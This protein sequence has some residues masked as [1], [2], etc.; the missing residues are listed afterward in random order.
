MSTILNSMKE[1]YDNR[2]LLYSMVVRDFKGK[3]KNSFFGFL[4]HFITPAVMIVLFYIVFTNIR[5]SPIDD[6]WIYLCAGMFPF[7]FFQTNIQSGSGCIVSNG[8]MIKKMYF[9]REII[10]FSQVIS[11]F[12]SLLIT[13]VGVV[14]IT[15]AFGFSPDPLALLF[16]PVMMLLSIIFALGYV[17]ILSAMSVFIRDVQHVMTVLARMIFWTTP[18][19]YLTSEV[20]G[21]LG[22][23][24]WCNPLTY[25]IESY[26][27][28]L[29]FGIVP[30]TTNLIIC[31]VLTLVSFAVGLIIFNKLKGKFAEKL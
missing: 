24:I 9:P 20:T 10:V 3:Y 8:G 16:L 11:T 30:N 2:N 26:H 25:F 28:I 14:L 4:W 21:V 18:I 17:F 5:V 7:T 15:W 1:V 12:I 23:I 31:S 19:F 13:C 27:D 6:Y 29:Y 22:T